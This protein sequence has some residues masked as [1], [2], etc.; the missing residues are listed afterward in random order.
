[1]EEVAS[2]VRI[3]FVWPEDDNADEAKEVLPILF[4]SA[5]LSSEL[6]LELDNLDRKCLVETR[7]FNCLDILMPDMYPDIDNT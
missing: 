2:D 4:S 3:I 1:M 7:S 6:E 5:M